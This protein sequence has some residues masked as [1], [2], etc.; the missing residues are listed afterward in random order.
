M[1]YRFGSCTPATPTC[2]WTV[3]EGSR[4]LRLELSVTELAREPFSRSPNAMR[5]FLGPCRIDHSIVIEVGDPQENTPG[6]H[7]AARRAGCR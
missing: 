6:R 3:A 7:V 1:L 4:F 5:A 2:A